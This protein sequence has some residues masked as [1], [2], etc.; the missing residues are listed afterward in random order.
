MITRPN[1]R[2]DLLISPASRARESLAPERLM[3]SE[4]ARSTRL[5]LP[6]LIRSSPAAVDHGLTLVHFSAQRKRFLWDRGCIYG[7]PWGCLGC[8]RGY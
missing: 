4:P 2:S 1:V 3:F 8:V 6:H 7:L 5:S